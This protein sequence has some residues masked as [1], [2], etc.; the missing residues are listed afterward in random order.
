[1][2]QPRQHHQT[3][4]EPADTVHLDRHTRKRLAIQWI[5]AVRA[6]SDCLHCGTHEPEIFEF[7]HREPKNK[8]STVSHLVHRG[9]PLKLIFQEAAKCDILC[10]SC[11]KRE[12]VRLAELNRE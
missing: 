6:Q 9:A 2:N 12:H 3:M 7:H 1:M 5:K 11:H 8:I 10:P 4:R